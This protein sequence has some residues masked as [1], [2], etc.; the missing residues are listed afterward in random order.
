MKNRLKI[1]KWQLVRRKTEQT[2]DDLSAA[3]FLAVGKRA[4]S[5]QKSLQTVRLPSGVVAVKTEAFRGCTNLQTVAFSDQ[6]NVGI[7]RAAFAGCA[8]LEQVEN[9]EQIVRIGEKAFFG[10]CGLQQ[11]S[12]GKSLCSLGEKAFAGSGL[13]EVTLPATLSFVG[14]G[15]FSDCANLTMLTM[16]EGCSALAPSLLQNCTALETVSFSNRVTDLPPALLR[17]CTKL[18]TVTVPPSLVRVGARAFCGCTA[19]TSLELPLGVRRIDRFAF[20]NL[21]RLQSVALPH[22]LKRLG[23]G[24]FGLGFSEKKIKLLVDNEYMIRR[25]KPKLFLC[26]SYF[27]T[28]LVLT[29]KTIEERKRERRRASVEQSPTHLMDP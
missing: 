5:R 10:C 20:S 18:E 27:R 12:F 28:E 1:K 22:S 3:E 7:G 19:L 26:G 29:G 9:A 8:K 16:E 23:F 17:G 25:L 13:E 11:V 14:R 24:A 21:P 15:A 4:F 2:H 6:N